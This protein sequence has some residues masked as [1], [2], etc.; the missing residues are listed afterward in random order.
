MKDE[1]TSKLLPYDE[2]L[3]CWHRRDRMTG[4]GIGEKNVRERATVDK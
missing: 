2:P 1:G 4:M 3:T